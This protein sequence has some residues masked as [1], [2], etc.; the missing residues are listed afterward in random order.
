MGV[1][2]PATGWSFQR[3]DPAMPGG[4]AGLGPMAEPSQGR[5]GS[6]PGGKK[7]MAFLDKNAGYWFPKI[8]LP[9][10]G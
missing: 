5:D 1:H 3:R 4:Y 8:E 7:P 9:L 2:T 6:M 10:N